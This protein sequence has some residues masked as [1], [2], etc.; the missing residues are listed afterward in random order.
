MKKRIILVLMLTWMFSVGTETVA[1]DAAR[2]DANSKTEQ[3]KDDKKRK[4]TKDAEVTF[5][6]SMTC[7]NC[8]AKIER[9]IA[10]EKGVKDL[11]VNLEKKLV[12][13]KYDPKKTDESALKSA[14]E[15]LEYRVEKVEPDKKE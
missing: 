7:E 4:K 5:S 11:K 15:D 3:K 2:T 9:H 12:T 8:K 6:V 1:Q 10:W 14:I 13:V